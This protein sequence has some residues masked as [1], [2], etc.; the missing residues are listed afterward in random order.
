MKTKDLLIISL[1]LAAVMV[2]FAFA[3]EARLPAGA[4]LPVH[5][6]AAGEA[7]R[8]AP[9]LRALLL[10]P[11]ILVALSG[12]FSLIPKLEPLQDKLAGSA[13]VL[14]IS[15]I[16]MMVIMAIVAGVIG[17][18][19]WGITPPVNAI[20]L[21]VGLLLVMIGN[22]LPKSR[23][24]FFV[25]IRTPWTITDTDNWIA[26]HRLGGKLMLLAGA[27]IVITSL[28]PVSPQT[29]GIVVLA[30]VLVAAVIPIIYS[31]WFWRQ[32]KDAA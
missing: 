7:D 9:A 17:L 18:P 24:G 2:G 21:G 31:W 30:S 20:M 19:A 1:L 4:Q 16:G 8:Y 13:P 14:R 26:T 10:P 15:W 32:K 6:N 29:T 12:L 11:V 5:W 3:T 22:A 25:G 23:P 27:A 28:F